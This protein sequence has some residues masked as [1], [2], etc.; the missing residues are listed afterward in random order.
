VPV[1]VVVFVVVVVI[2]VAAVVAVA[3]VAVVAVV[4]L[5][6][7]VVVAR[8][9][10][11]ATVLYTCTLHPRSPSCQSSALSLQPENPQQFV[12]VPNERAKAAYEADPKCAWLT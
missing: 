10:A 5:V 1:V 3:V 8:L 2:I 6:V 4:L 12:L 7:V 9:S 11:C